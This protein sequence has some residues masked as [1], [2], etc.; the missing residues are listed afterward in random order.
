MKIK[1]QARPFPGSVTIMK[2]LT[3][4]HNTKKYKALIKKEFYIP[5][6]IKK[7]T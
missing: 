3:V 2:L 6:T 4:K 5:I 7:E 1:T